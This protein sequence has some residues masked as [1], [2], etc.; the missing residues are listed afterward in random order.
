MYYVAI[1]MFL[2]EDAKGSALMDLSTILIA[3][4]ILP[5]EC[6]ALMTWM[7]MDI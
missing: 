4:P 1:A 3:G 5:A 6:A 2:A 7:T